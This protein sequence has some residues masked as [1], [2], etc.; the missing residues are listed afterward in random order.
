[1]ADRTDTL[2]IDKPNVLLVKSLSGL[3]TDPT[4]GIDF[5][6]QHIG[7]TDFNPVYSAKLKPA[8]FL[9]NNLERKV[10]TA[11]FY[12]DIDT[13][14][15]SE[16]RRSYSYRSS[17]ILIP[18]A[19]QLKKLQQLNTSKKILV[20]FSD[21]YECSS[22]LNVYNQDRISLLNNPE[23]LAQK[24]KKQLELPNDLSDI[25]LYL[26]YHPKT[27]E[28]NRLFSCVCLLYKELFKGSGLNIRIGMEQKLNR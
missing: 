14:F 24:L 20:L 27:T 13:L 5:R 1:M 16:N 8:S 2:T 12:K 3:D 21:G 23:D 4:F 18:L 9:D 11:R 28:D 22:L 7:N 15:K 6:F 17:S 19:I 26:I 10:T 25:T